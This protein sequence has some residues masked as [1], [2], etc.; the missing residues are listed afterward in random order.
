MTPVLGREGADHRIVSRDKG[1]P[2]VAA[3]RAVA[4]SDGQGP[5]LLESA[6]PL[7]GLTASGARSTRLLQVP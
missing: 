4:P 1:R 3:A 2:A 7:R 5:G 6:R